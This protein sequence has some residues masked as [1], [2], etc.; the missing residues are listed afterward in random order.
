MGGRRI[1]ERPR[2]IKLLEGTSARTILLIAPAGYGKTT[3]ARQWAERQDR[4]HW[5]T[6]RAGSADVAQLAVDLASVL[7]TATQGLE[8]YVAQL[9][10]ALPNPSQS[11][12]HIAAAIAKLVG[13]LSAE[14]L[15]VDDLHVT[16]EDGAAADLLRELQLQT[17]LRLLLS[18]RIRPPWAS[19]RLQLYGELLELG[20]DDLALTRDEVIQIVGRRTRE[21]NDILERTRGW[22]AVVSLAAQTNAE[23]SSATGA[24]ATTLFRYFAEEL[25]RASS[26]ALQAQL[27]TLALLPKLSRDLVDLA[28]QADSQMI[29]DQAIESGLATAGAESAE[30]HPLVREYLVTK[31]AASKG[32]EEQVRAV[33]G[34][35]LDQGL[36]DHAFE[37]VRRF[38]ALDLLD[39]LI[40]RSFKSLVSSGRIATAEQ[41]AA[42]GHVASHVSPLV[43]LIDA[44]LA[45][46]NGFFSRAAVVAERAARHLGE[47]HSL[48]SHAW[49]I[50]GQGAQLSFEDTEAL[51]HFEKARETASNDEDLRDAL[52]G[53]ALTSCQA[54]APSARQSIQPLLTRRDRSPI[55]RVRA[56]AARVLLDRVIGSGESIQLSEALHALE[57]VADPR[58]RT[59][60]LNVCAYHL[61]LRAEY[62][63]AQELA[64]RM[65]E[66]ADTYQ[67]T[68]AQP[69]AHWAL[70]AAAL[71]RRQMAEANSWLRRVERAADEGRS[72][73]LLL[74]ASCLRA[75]QL[76]ALRRPE[77]AWSALTVDETLPANRGMRG[78]LY[79]IRGLTLAVLGRQEESQDWSSRARSLTTCVEAHAYS[80]CAASVLALEGDTPRAK[81]ADTLGEVGRLGVW[82]AL[83]S[84]MRASPALLAT[85]SEVGPLEPAVVATLRRSHDFDLSKQAGVDIGRRPRGVSATGGLSPREREVLELVGQGLSNQ[86]IARALFISKS[87]VKVHIRHILEK[88]GARSRTEAATAGED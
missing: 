83:V 65:R 69:H 84:A 86:D 13:D 3:L 57:T 34:L 79:A 73:P 64:E 52:W 39:E 24:A 32:A 51:R 72:G 19:A 74:N 28:L 16:A 1:I 60:I 80:A 35:S 8:S 77:D 70:A 14:T 59:S 42:F 61:I 15:L 29:I 53:C 30:L 36:W 54:E 88:T 41:I 2:L 23:L 31:V 27:L 33:I 22:P 21:A 67:L 9:M 68:W 40:G 71:G 87:T 76:L 26:S 47:S 50:A 10:Q 62:D 4:V 11:A 12:S 18:S 46:R 17:G 85:L 66:T 78:E 7:G 6:A 82:D 55:D 49:W 37:L 45:F 75:R 58:I 63:D 44:E 38:E 56:T 43:D 5:Y 25:F 81:I 20:A 48:A